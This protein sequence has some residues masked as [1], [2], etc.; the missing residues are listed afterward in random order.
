MCVYVFMFLAGL[1]VEVVLEK[2]EE[3]VLGQHLSTMCVCFYVWFQSCK[4]FVTK[5]T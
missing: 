4:M 5:R 1:I 3:N 2:I